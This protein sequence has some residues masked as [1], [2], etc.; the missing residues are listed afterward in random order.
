MHLPTLLSLSSLLLL[1]P[2]TA[3]IW[4]PSD[5]CPTR[6]HTTLSS[7]DYCETNATWHLCSPG[8]RLSTMNSIHAALTSCPNLTSLDLRL[9]TSGCTGEA[10]SRW[11]FPLL[12]G[13]EEKYANLTSLRLHGYE[14]SRGVHDEGTSRRWR[15]GLD[16]P[17]VSR[18]RDAAQQVFRAAPAQ[19][20]LD[21]WLGAMNWSGI[22]EL[23][24]EPVRD[25]HLAKLP[26]I[27]HSLQRLETTNASFV[28]ALRNDTL[29]HL[30]YIERSDDGRSARE[31]P[32]ILA[33]Q[34]KL[35]SLE[36]RSPEL[37]DRVFESVFDVNILPA[38]AKELEHVT[39]NV[40]RNG[41]WPLETF[42]VLASLPALRSADM[43][44]GIQSVC[45]Q[46]RTLRERTMTRV[47]KWKHDLEGYCEGEDQYQRPFVGKEGAEE[48]FAYMRKEKK[49][50]EFTN[51]T[52]HVGDWSRPWSGPI[53]FPDWLENK[54]SKAVCDAE[55]G[56][57]KCVVLQA[58]RYWEWTSR[59]W[60][61]E[62]DRL[63]DLYD[64]LSDEPDVENGWF[65]WP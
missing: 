7:T 42:D 10:P 63:L 28:Y 53:Y 5:A 43:Y 26:P 25:E 51:L 6:I 9:Q 37:S 64:R 19:T 31:L 56:V 40:A 22:E 15:R 65:S 11:D 34:G 52:I 8:V 14:F 41:T 27:L 24:I 3:R 55:G 1:P 60:Y 61:I 45:A 54:R 18:V 39:L 44:M 23:M 16:W 17:P 59:D 20:H 35:T 46:Q 48:V 50:V 30:T 58:D 29:A 36:V 32:A 33:H 49:G 38:L 2:V 4:T 47:E 62:E 21:L 12:A 57:E 13:R